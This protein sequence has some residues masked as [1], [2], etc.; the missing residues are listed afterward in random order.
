MHLLFA[1][2]AGRE[3]YAAAI[4]HPTRYWSS[5]SPYADRTCVAAECEE[6][7]GKID[8]A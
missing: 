1:R 7:R 4:A 8:R 3:N 6:K 5:T 2:W